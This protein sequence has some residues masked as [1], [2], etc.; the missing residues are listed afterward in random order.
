[1]KKLLKIFYILYGIKLSTKKEIFKSV[2]ELRIEPSKILNRKEICFIGFDILIPTCESSLTKSNHIQDQ[3]SQI[4]KKIYENFNEEEILNKENVKII[5]DI[6]DS[7]DINGLL[8]NDQDLLELKEFSNLNELPKNSKFS[9]LYKNLYFYLG[10]FISKSIN[11]ENNENSVPIFLTKENYFEAVRMLEISC[12]I[13]YMNELNW[14]N[15]GFLYKEIFER[16]IDIIDFPL[17]TKE[18]MLKKGRESLRLSEEQNFDKDLLTMGCRSLKCLEISNLLKKEKEVINS[19]GNI[20]FQF[21][22]LKD[23]NEQEIDS[24][25]NITEISFLNSNK[26]ETNQFE[27]FLFLGKLNEKYLNFE[28]ALNFYF[29]ACGYCNI[30][31]NNEPFYFLYR[32][33]FNLNEISSKIDLTKYFIEFPINAFEVKRKTKSYHDFIPTEEEIKNLNFEGNLKKIFEGFFLCLLEDE[34]DYKS[35]LY[36]GKLF[37]KVGNISLS[38]HILGGIFKLKTSKTTKKPDHFEFKIWVKENSL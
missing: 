16:M 26:L 3:L 11:K 31:V 15:L 12:S 4:L 19:I 29:K 10:I 23:I 17:Q 1:M 30:K 21:L 25:K 36:L 22:K 6:I 18:L 7:R 14:K 2:E 9:S 8:K 35:L 32:L 34:F 37:E 24:F 38:K 13:D 33:L 27:N 28:E 5:D 20:S